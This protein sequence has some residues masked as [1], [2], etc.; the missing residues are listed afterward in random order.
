MIRKL[1]I[2]ALTILLFSCSDDDDTNCPGGLNETWFTNFK[3]ELN[4]NCEIEVSIFRGNYK[5]QTVY[6]ELITDGA[7]NFQ[8]MITFYN[9]NGDVEAELTAEQSNEYLDNEGQDDL[10]L[11]TC[12]DSD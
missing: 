9:C 1:S 4:S 2:L 3:A 8:A 12:S 11:F 5:G 6:Y 10:K 7:V